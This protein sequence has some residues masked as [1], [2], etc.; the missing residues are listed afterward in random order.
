MV[1]RWDYHCCGGDEY[2]CGQEE[3]P[4]GEFVEYED[5]A[6]LEKERDE[7]RAKLNRISQVCDSYH[8]GSPLP[9]L[10]SLL[11]EID[12]IMKGKE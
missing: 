11:L 5:Y 8:K 3:S 9:P 1:T 7:A 10:L 12:E 2:R 4:E 6:A